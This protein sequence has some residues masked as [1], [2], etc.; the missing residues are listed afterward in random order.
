MDLWCA[1]FCCQLESHQDEGNPY[2]SHVQSGLSCGGD[3]SPWAIVWMSYQ[4]ML[5]RCSTGNVH[6]PFWSWSR[7]WFN[8][9]FECTLLF[10]IRLQSLQ[11]DS[12]LTEQVK[13]WIK[14][15]LAPGSGVV[16]LYL[17][18]RYSAH[19]RGTFHEWLLFLQMRGRI[20]YAGTFAN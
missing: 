19:S 7:I 13:P 15:S 11:L 2:F 8:Y 18:K 6:V 5:F 3:N 9:W 16:T 10:G 12:V 20:W 1:P 14:T 17:E 4:G